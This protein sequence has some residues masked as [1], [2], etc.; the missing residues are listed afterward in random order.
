MDVWLMDAVF[1]DALMHGGHPSEGLSQAGLNGELGHHA[2]R[3]V[4]PSRFALKSEPVLAGILELTD[5]YPSDVM[6]AAFRQARS[7]QTYSVAFLRGLLQAESPQWTQPERPKAH[8]LALP[9][10]LN[11]D[12]SPYGRV[13]Q[14]ASERRWAQ[15]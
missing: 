3:Q 6:R 5:I 12:L 2:P 10:D 14:G 15:K 13:L 7:C 4:S 8:P 1:P 9:L 11:T